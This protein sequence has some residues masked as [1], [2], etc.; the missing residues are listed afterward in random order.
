MLRVMNLSHE[1]NFGK[2]HQLLIGTVERRTS[3]NAS[4][5]LAYG[6]MQAIHQVTLRVVLV[7]TPNG[8]NEAEVFFSTDIRL[9]PVKIINYFILRWNLEVTFFRNTCSPWG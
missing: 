4:A 8:K 3:L 9:E 2:Y 6:T 1:P 5:L 7:K